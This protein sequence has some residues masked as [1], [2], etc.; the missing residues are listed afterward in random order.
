[1]F[2]CDGQRWTE[3]HDMYFC[4]EILLIK[5]HQF[6]S[7]SKESGASWKMVSEDLNTITELNFSTTQKSVRDR[8]RLLIEKQKKK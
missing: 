2:Q 8:Y 5:P 3:P 7:R 6:K 1:M 4:R